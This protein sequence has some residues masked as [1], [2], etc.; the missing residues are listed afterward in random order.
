MFNYFYCAFVWLV[1]VAYPNISGAG[2]V[3]DQLELGVCTHLAQQKHSSDSYF[4]IFNEIGATSFRDEYYWSR[5]EKRAGELSNPPVLNEVVKAIHRAPAD[6]IKPLVVLSYGNFVYDA[7]GLPV[8]EEYQLAF[9]RYASF[10]ANNFKGKARY[11]EVWNEWNI[12]KGSSPKANYGDPADYARLLK[13]TYSAIKA[14][15]GDAI[16]LGGSV[17]NWDSKWI[18]GF[19]SAGGAQYADGVAVHPYNYYSPKRAP[20]DVIYWLDSLHHLLDKNALKIPIYVTEIGWPSYIGL[21]GV[22]PSVAADYV[23]RFISLAAT[24]KFI[25]GVW[26]YDLVNDGGNLFVHEDNFGL[27]KPDLEE[28]PQ[29]IAFRKISSLLSESSWVRLIKPTKTAYIVE[30]SSPRK[31]SWLLWSQVGSGESIAIKTNKDA[32]PTKFVA[33]EDSSIGV[34]FGGQR[35]NIVIGVSPVLISGDQNF[36]LSTD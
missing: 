35:K 26:W 2:V 8:A 25:K 24:R 28:K 6:A 22:T 32:L 16:V 17:T 19:I 1:L 7:G 27:Y 3:P 4:R 15:D 18:S 21:N 23:V 33:G 36:V 12:G 34:V 10:V 29:A 30:F 13:K 9:S 31:K 20:E 5:V 14:V 11:Y